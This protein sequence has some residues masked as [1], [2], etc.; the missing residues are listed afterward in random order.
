M[1]F[2]VLCITSLL[3]VFNKLY[4]PAGSIVQHPTLFRW[5]TATY[6]TH[7]Y[8]VMSDEMKYITFRIHCICKNIHLRTIQLSEKFLVKRM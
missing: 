6:S 5:Y 8:I 4:D 3:I 7:T 2:Q 1:C